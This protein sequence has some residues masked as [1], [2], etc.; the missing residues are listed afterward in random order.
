MLHR[1]KSRILLGLIFAG[2]T[3]VMSPGRAPA[4]NDGPGIQAGV[5]T[6]NVAGGWGLLFASSKDLKCLYAT[7]G[8]GVERYTGKVQ[9]LGI[10]IGY[11]DGGTITWAVFAPS[12]NLTPG[13]LTGTYVGASAEA[14]AGRGVGANILVGG[15]SAVS[16]QPLSI[17]GQKGLNIAAGI[18]SITLN[19]FQ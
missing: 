19:Y 10:D 18:G 13:G 7:A 16:L 2:V 6:C 4:T 5:L 1:V 15:S 9:K 3:L 12:S 8:R 17:S 14:T 11:T